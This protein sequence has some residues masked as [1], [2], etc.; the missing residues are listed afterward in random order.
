M[1]QGYPFGVD[2]NSL[3][4]E[5]EVFF[6]Y[7]IQTSDEVEMAVDLL[8]V[9]ILDDVAASILRCRERT[10]LRESHEQ[11]VSRV[12]YVESDSISILSESEFDLSTVLRKIL[13]QE[14][15]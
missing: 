1:C 15:S 6:A 8:Q 12:Y 7:G 9:L 11:T 4:V 10:S 2:P 13:K 14:F 3:K 5:R